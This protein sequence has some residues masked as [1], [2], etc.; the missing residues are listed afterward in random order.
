MKADWASGSWRLFEDDAPESGRGLGPETA[1][2]GD[3]RYVGPMVLRQGVTEERKHGWFSV[4][5]VTVS[6][7]LR[8]AEINDGNRP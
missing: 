7:F 6:E 4:P 1:I 5:G 2:A 3:I 8:M